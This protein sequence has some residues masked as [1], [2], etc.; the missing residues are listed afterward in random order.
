[1][2]RVVLINTHTHTQERR[3]AAHAA[4]PGKTS[5]PAL[6][7]TASWKHRE[8][9]AARRER[10]ERAWGRRECEEQPDARSERIRGYSTDY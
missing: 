2:T 1:M 6:G 8:S 7:A 3:K 10:E 4:T 9:A 5:E